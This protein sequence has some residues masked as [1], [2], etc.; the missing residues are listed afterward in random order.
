VVK[1]LSSVLK[2]KNFIHKK[3]I[4]P[5][6]DVLF[7]EQTEKCRTPEAVAAEADKEEVPADLNLELYV[8]HVA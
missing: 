3:D 5:Q 1:A 7:V 2:I 8:R 6:K 4:P